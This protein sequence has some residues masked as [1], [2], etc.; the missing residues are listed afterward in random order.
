M[1]RDSSAGVWQAGSRALRSAWPLVTVASVGV[2]IYLRFTQL[3][4]QIVIDD[5]WHAI[6]KVIE[7][8]VTSI[9]TSF[10]LADYSIPLTLYY[11]FL[12]THGGLTEWAMHV[13]P[14]IAGIALLV[15]APALLR[16]QVPASVVAS[17]SRRRSGK[18][19]AG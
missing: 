8:G 1:M 10:G 5:E 16:G 17:W 3:R 4:T 2:G 14:L 18:G 7:S 11:L 12:S 13:P 19:G 9:A 6:H 15:L